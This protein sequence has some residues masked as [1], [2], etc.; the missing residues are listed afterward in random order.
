MRTAWRVGRSWLNDEAHRWRW[1][2]AAW[3]TWSICATLGTYVPIFGSVRDESF[4]MGYNPLPWLALGLVAA[5]VN[6][7]FWFAIGCASQ[8]F[9]SAPDYRNA[10]RLPTTMHLVGGPVHLLSLL[11]FWAWQ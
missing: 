4:A 1:V 8:W 3:A 2:P 5:A 10:R 7:T 6:W 9:H 11:V